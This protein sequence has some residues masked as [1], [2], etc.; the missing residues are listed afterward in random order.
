VLFGDSHAAQWFPAV[1][2][3]ASSQG[4]KL[5]SF[6]KTSC[7]AIDVPRSNKGAFKYSKCKK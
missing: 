7:P 5:F 6:T 4:Y 2:N 1:E 3:I